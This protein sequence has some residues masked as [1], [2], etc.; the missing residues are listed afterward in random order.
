MHT[1][2]QAWEHINTT[3]KPPHDLFIILIIAVV[4]GNN[5]QPTVIIT[6]ITLKEGN[7][8]SDRGV[9]RKGISPRN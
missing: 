2:E 6:S 5:P 3:G 4:C 1:L 9:K 8:V 7:E